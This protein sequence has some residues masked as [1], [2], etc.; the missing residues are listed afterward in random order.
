MGITICHCEERSDVAISDNTQSFQFI[1]AV[2]NTIYLASSYSSATRNTKELF[3]QPLPASSSCGGI[4]EISSPGMASP[5]PLD[6]SAMM[7]A[8]L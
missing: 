3:Y 8:S 2:E 7:E 1:L 6:T 5:N 4:L